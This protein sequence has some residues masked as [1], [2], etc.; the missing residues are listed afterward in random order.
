MGKHFEKLAVAF[1]RRSRTSSLL[2]PNPQLLARTDYGFAGM[3]MGWSYKHNTAC[4][5]R[6]PAVEHWSL[7]DVLSLSCARLVADG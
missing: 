6:S 4:W 3:L 1:A 7:A 2:M 5:L